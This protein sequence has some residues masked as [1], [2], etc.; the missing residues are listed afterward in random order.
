MTLHSASLSHRVPKL[1]PALPPGPKFLP[2][3]PLLLALRGDLMGALSDLARNYGDLVHFKILGHPIFLLNH[4]DLV[5]EVLVTQANNFVKGPGLKQAKRVILGQGL[6]TTEGQVHRQQRQRIQ[7]IFQRTSVERYAPATVECARRFLERWQAEAPRQGSL[8]I[9]QEMMRLTLSVV[10]K[11]TFDVDLDI[12]TG[13]KTITSAVLTLS[14]WIFYTVVLPFTRWMEKLPFGPGARVREAREGLEALV[15]GMIADRRA[16]GLQ[17]DL[18]SMLM[19]DGEGKLTDRQ[20]RDQAMIIFLG[21]TETMANT[22]TWTWYLLSQHPEVEARLHAE[23]DSVLGGRPPAVEDLEKLTY[24]RN[25]LAESLRL[26][27]PAWKIDRRAVEACEIGGYTVP[28]GAS[29]VMCQWLIHRDA[30]YYPNPDRFDPER[31]TPEAQ[32]VRPKYAYFPFGGGARVCIGEH[33]AWL[34]GTLLLATVAQRWR[35]RLVPG[36][37]IVLR[38]RIN[39]RSQH[40]MQMTLEE[41]EVE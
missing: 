34:Q 28:A 3:R 38:Q 33:L 9:F 14:E 15:Y 36:H 27:P 30:R 6:L 5:R 13:A 29:V 12:E 20:I 11:T 26:Y 35:L 23:L 7:P 25:V 32:A 4:P 19:R 31:W 37:P 1:E 16:K 41:R 22:L 10:S 8:D 21:G 17:D 40:G 18:L 24:T 39:L 2:L